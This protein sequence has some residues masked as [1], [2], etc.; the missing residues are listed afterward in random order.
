MNCYAKSCPPNI[1]LRHLPMYRK[2]QRILYQV[3]GS[4]TEILPLTFYHICLID[5]LSILCSLVFFSWHV[6]KLQILIKT[7]QHGYHLLAS[8]I[9][10]QFFLELEVKH[11]YH[12]MYMA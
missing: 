3:F 2:V 5:Y 7:L 8:N 4:T 1:L 11:T 9:C 12:E 6:S 10:L